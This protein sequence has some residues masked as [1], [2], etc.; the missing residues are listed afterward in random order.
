MCINCITLYDLYEVLQ[1]IA[2]YE[3]SQPASFVRIALHFLVP[4][5][6]HII[7]SNMNITIVIN[8]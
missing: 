7:T 1:K 3:K 6:F 5:S 2:L 8:Q 4:Q